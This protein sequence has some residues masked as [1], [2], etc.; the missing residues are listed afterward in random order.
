MSKSK[1]KCKNKPKGYKFNLG[2]V[3]ASPEFNLITKPDG[4]DL[5]N[6]KMQPQGKGHSMWMGAAIQAGLAAD[7]AIGKAIG[8]GKSS[9]VGDFISSLPGGGVL[10]GAV[11]ALFGSK[12]NDAKVAEIDSDVQDLYNTSLDSSSSQSLMSSVGN[13][14][15]G[16]DFTRSDIGSDGLFSSKAKD[17]YAKK[18]LE[19]ATARRYAESNIANASENLDTNQ[20]R[21]IL[22]SIKKFGGTLDSNGTMFDT[23]LNFINEGG[24]H[25][26]NPYEGVQMGVAPDGLPNLVEE[27]EVKYNNYIFS[28]R[29]KPSK[30]L[31]NKFLL[32]EYLEGK[33][34]A[35]IAKKLSKENIERPNDPISKRGLED[36]MMKLR[37][38]QEERKSRLPKKSHTYDVGGFMKVLQYAPAAGNLVGLIDNAFTK[39]DY[40][41]ADLIMNSVKGPSTVG[42]T[43]LGDYLSYNPVDINYQSN[44]LTG[45]S[46]ATRRAITDLSNGNRGVAMANL[47]AQD[48]NTQNALGEL[49][50]GAE[51]ENFNRRSAVSEFNRGTNQ[52][53]SELEFR[54]N[55]ANQASLDAYKN[56]SLSAI[57]AAA[58]MRDDVENARAQSMSSNLTGLFDNLGG[59]AR[60]AINMD[61][62]EKLGTTKSTEGF[63]SGRR[64]NKKSKPSSTIT[65]PDLSM[66]S[67]NP[68]DDFH[69]AND[70]REAF[71]RLLGT[72]PLYIKR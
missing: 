32:P 38:A 22:G 9:G 1:C 10:G 42:F 30:N 11:N 49:M 23:G 31:L 18:Q 35:E 33:T 41:N 50:R 3:T 16:N 66:Y 14:D 72:A 15:W 54:A 63:Y 39:P 6:I 48:Y 28:N 2:G 25:E 40:G 12:I 37:N 46:A 7:A 13:I 60:D 19:L 5:T 55:Q 24:T 47:I 43:P 57:T 26:E 27:G 8:G 4:T 51:Q 44:K 45:Q 53:N 61:I 20:D 67:N 36:T 17:L 52:F 71:L 59:I 64:K 69:L 65:I 70:E 58:K 34:F 21:R 29:L 56:R 62:A 68:L